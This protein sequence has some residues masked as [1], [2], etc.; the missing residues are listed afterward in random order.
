[1]T[2][3][4][5]LTQALRRQ[6]QP[7]EDVL[8]VAR[9]PWPEKID[10]SERLLQ[11]YGDDLDRASRVRWTTGWASLPPSMALFH[12]GWLPAAGSNLAMR[13]TAIV[14][15]ALERY[16]RDHGGAPPDSLRALVPGYLQ[17]I[18][19]DPFSGQPPC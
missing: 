9:Q 3:R 19:D 16:R 11:R 6:L 5:L 12:L 4:P 13:R 14:V 7:Y 8:A 18:P 1:V 15:F 17:A 10:A 2:F